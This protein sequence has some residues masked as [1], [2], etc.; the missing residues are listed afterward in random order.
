MSIVK[1]HK[2]G[3]IG[4]PGSEYLTRKI[5]K[6]IKRLYVERYE[7]LSANLAKRH[8][9]TEAEVL[10]KVIFND[11]LNS[12]VIPSSK[13]PDEFRA[14]SIE[15]AVKYTRFLNG[16]VKSEI[17]DPVRGLKIYF[18]YDVSNCSPI[19]VEGVDEPMS[20]TVND[21]L[22]FLFTTIDAM[23]LAGAESIT[24]VL[25]TYPYARQHKKSGREA[26]TAALFGEM[27]EVLG[28]E[29]II[30]LD[31]HCREIENCFRTCHLENLHASYQI[32][33]ELGKVMDLSDP[34]IT[35]VAPDTG[36]VSRNK[37]YAEALHRPLAMLYK[38]RDYS[39]VTKSAKS[40]NIKGVKLLGD[41][42]GKTVLI[43]DDM[44]GSGGTMLLA[45]K[46]LKEF[47]AKRIIC[48]ISLPF[49]NGSAVDSFDQA[50]KEGT[51]DYVIGTNAVYHDDAFLD[52][53]WFIQADISELFARVISHLHHGRAIS[54]LLDNR[55]IV[56]RLID[57]SQAAGL[58]K[59]SDSSGP[60]SATVPDHENS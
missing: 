41:V 57:S 20:F 15:I 38:E 7:K 53:K 8:D 32:M 24:L 18:I 28:V 35:V 45:M 42:K 10:R 37:F 56:Q 22:M 54:P 29:R 34:D 11:D 5:V 50:Y 33:V 60:A 23:R 46:T 52:R 31:L 30:T 40:T 58:A 44:L 49:F 26:L 36:A 6:H 19:K 48:I 59:S 9:M 21:H 4:G 51:F 2:L 27:C 16:E 17:L 1:P 3:I 13:C 55:R 14:P 25:P 43:A 12:K 39:V 47:G